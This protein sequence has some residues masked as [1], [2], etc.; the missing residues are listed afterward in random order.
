MSSIIR[1]AVKIADSITSSLGLQTQVTHKVWKAQQP[2]GEETYSSTTKRGAIV[3]YKQRKVMGVDGQ[4]VVSN[5]SVFFP[6][7]VRV[8]VKDLIILPDGYVGR[9]VALDGPMDP[10]TGTGYVT[11]VYLG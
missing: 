9:V 3:E 2:D 1:N 6:R 11:G 4:E 5:A 10:E 7:A 8:S